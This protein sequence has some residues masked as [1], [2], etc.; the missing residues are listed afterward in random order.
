MGRQEFL[1]KIAPPVSR[2]KLEAAGNADR[3]KPAVPPS[4]PVKGEQNNQNIPPKP[5]GNRRDHKGDP[6]KR[7]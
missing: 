2:A 5:N 1:F 6:H 4:V 3:P 7:R